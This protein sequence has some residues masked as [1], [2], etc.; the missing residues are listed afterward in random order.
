M[1][2][3][4]GGAG[5]VLMAQAGLFDDCDAAVSWHP[6]DDNGIWSINFHAQQKVEFTF[7]GNEKKSANVKRSHAVILSGRTESETSS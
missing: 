2:A 7:T 4:E 3:E 5:K 6:T 1:P